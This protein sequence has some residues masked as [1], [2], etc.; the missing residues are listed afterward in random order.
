MRMPRSPTG[1]RAPQRRPALRGK[2]YHG[3]KVRSYLLRTRT[4]IFSSN[5]D[6]AVPANGPEL[7][8]HR[9][10]R[11][12]IECIDESVVRVLGGDSLYPKPS[13]PAFIC[14]FD[15]LCASNILQVHYV[16]PSEINTCRE[17]EVYAPRTSRVA[18]VSHL[19]CT[20][21]LFDPEPEALPGRGAGFSATSS[22][23]RIVP[24][25]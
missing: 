7:R 25:S 18:S 9:S 4:F 23:R 6:R 1:A 11:K 21:V 17:D 10:Q 8:R 12:R 16:S 14:K 19:F 3:G 15:Y 13:A 24:E 20:C 22:R 5:H 2:D